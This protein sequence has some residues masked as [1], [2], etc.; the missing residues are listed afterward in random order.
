MELPAAFG[1]PVNED[2]GNVD[3]EEDTIQS[4]DFTGELRRLTETGAS[5]RRSFVEQLENAFSAPLALELNFNFDGERL[6]VPDQPPVSRLPFALTKEGGKGEERNE[7][8]TQSATFDKYNE[9]ESES[10]RSRTDDD[11]PLVPVSPGSFRPSNGELNTSFKFGGLPKPPP[12]GVEKKFSLSDII[13]P[14]LHARRLANPP[15]ALSGGRR[16]S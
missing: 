11:E 4:F 15:T 6:S 16:Q 14:P 7:A 8:T 10:T 2:D 3:E 9:A 12:V 13:P 5:N 1:T